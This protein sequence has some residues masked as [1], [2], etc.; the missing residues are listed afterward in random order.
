MANLNVNNTKIDFKKKSHHFWTCFEAKYDKEAPVLYNDFSPLW[1]TLT[2]TSNRTFTCCL[3]HSSHLSGRRFVQA[4]AQQAKLERAEEIKNELEIC[5]KISAER[6][7]NKCAKHFAICKDIVEQM[8]DFATKVG[9]YHQLT[10]KYV[11][12]LLFVI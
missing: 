11:T 12:V 6:A 3:P 7:Q 5:Q 4:L 8:I 1:I 2:V 10:D 9:E